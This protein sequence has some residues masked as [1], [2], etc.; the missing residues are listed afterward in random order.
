MLFGPVT[1][2]ARGTARPGHRGVKVRR[3]RRYAGANKGPLGFFQA[4]PPRLR[5]SAT[6]RALRSGMGQQH[7]G[8]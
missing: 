1:W 7:A 8:A 4:I 2:T 6:K 5:A 3:L